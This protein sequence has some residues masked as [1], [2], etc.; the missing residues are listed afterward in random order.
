MSD[1]CTKYEVKLLYSKMTSIKQ[2]YHANSRETQI[3]KSAGATQ[4]NNGLYRETLSQNKTFFFL[5]KKKKGR[6]KKRRRKR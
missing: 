1:I 3:S 6:V 2:A 5:K 4:Y